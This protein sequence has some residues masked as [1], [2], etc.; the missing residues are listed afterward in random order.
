MWNDEADLDTHA[1]S[2][3]QDPAASDVPAALQGAL[4]RAAHGEDNRV[5]RSKAVGEPPLML[6]ISV[7]WRSRRGRR[8]RRPARRRT[9]AARAR[10]ARGNIGPR[11]AG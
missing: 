4:W 6:A 8:L 11:R 5:P 7:R 3:L 10:H 2:H 9:P 1:P